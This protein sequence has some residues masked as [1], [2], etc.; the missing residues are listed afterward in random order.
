MKKVKK[1]K[2]TDN[3][4]EVYLGDDPATLEI[5][6]REIHS[7]NLRQTIVWRLDKDLEAGNFVGFTWSNGTP[8]PNPFGEPEISSDGNSLTITDLN[9]SIAPKGKT[10]SYVITVEYGGN[11]YVSKTTTNPNPTAG[12][13]TVKDPV[14]INK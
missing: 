13:K 5:E 4:I 7:N 2:K 6:D 10:Y 12:P 11:L 1:P 9:G 14:I 8:L 3:V